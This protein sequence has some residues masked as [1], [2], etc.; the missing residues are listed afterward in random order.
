MSAKKD[1]SQKLEIVKEFSATGEIKPGG[2]DSFYDF[3]AEN[4]LRV[5]VEGVGATNVVVVKGKIRRQAT[6][7]TLSTIT[8]ASSATIDLTLIDDVIF[9]VTTYDASGTP[10]LIASSFFGT[11]SGSVAPNVISPNTSG[12]VSNVTATITAQTITKPVGAV[13]FMLLADGTNTASIRWAV[14]ATASSTVGSLYEA[15][16][17]SGYIPLA[18]NISVIAISGSQGVSVQWVIQ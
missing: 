9:D 4:L 12:S 16:R 13:G 15:G 2:T 3:A 14:G 8:G 10:K 1:L 17:S 18:A 11:P 6:Y 7:S 5:A